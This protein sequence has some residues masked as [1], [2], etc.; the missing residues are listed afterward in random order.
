[1][2]DIISEALKTR[3]RVG[4]TF[5]ERMGVHSP[6]LAESRDDRKAILQILNA[7]PLGKGEERSFEVSFP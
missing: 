3:Q 6:S 2:L 5:C 1:M 4:R 7:M